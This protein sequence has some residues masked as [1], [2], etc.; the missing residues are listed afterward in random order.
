MLLNDN[1]AN[2][3]LGFDTTFDRLR[4]L[5]TKDLPK[6][7]PYNIVKS[8]DNK[9]VVELAVAGFKK[10]EIDIEIHDRT[11]RI[12]GTQENRTLTPDS[13]FLHRGIAS[14]NFQKEFTISETIEGKGAD[15]V[16]GILYVYLENRVPDEKK[17]KKIPFGNPTFLTE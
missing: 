13:K 2:T 14:R 3:F 17:P 9:F 4:D 7:P 6:Y 5:A 11:L 10:D 15:L 1:V 12:T 8:G 16:D